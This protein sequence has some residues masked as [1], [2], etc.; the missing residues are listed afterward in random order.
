MRPIRNVEARA[1]ELVRRRTC[2]VRARV[3]RVRVRDV[4]SRRRDERIKI[5]TAGLAGGW[6]KRDKF[7]GGAGDGVTADSLAEKTPDEVGIGR[8]AVHPLP[9]SET[10]EG[11]K[12]TVAVDVA[13]KV[14]RR[15]SKENTERTY[16]LMTKLNKKLNNN[17]AISGFGLIAATD[18]AKVV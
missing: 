7:G 3:C 9:P 4:S 17:A 10:G 8:E 2:T 16:K 5:V 1:Q 14:S 11:L 13:N 6:D 18:W 15:S 12:D